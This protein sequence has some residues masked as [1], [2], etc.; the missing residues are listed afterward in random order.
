LSEACGELEV[1]VRKVWA[2][3]LE[4]RGAC[5]I[6]LETKSQKSALKLISGWI[7]HGLVTKRIESLEEHI[8]MTQDRKVWAITSLGC[9]FKREI[10]EMQ[11]KIQV[12]RCI[13]PLEA[14]KSRHIKID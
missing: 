9:F 10:T 3:R 13:F 1:L 7:V 14:E 2:E 4:R 5:K 8:E 12:V 11:R 6:P